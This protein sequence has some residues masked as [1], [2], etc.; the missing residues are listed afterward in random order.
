MRE[1]PEFLQQV[2]KHFP[3][4]TRLIVGSENKS[5]Y[6]TKQLSTARLQHSPCEWVRQATIENTDLP[7][8]VK[9]IAVPC[10]HAT[11]P[12]VPLPPSIPAAFHRRGADGYQSP[13]NARPPSPRPG[14]FPL[15]PIPTAL[16]RSASTSP[17]LSLTPTP[18]CPL[19]GRIHTRRVQRPF[20]APSPKARPPL[21]LPPLPRVWRLL[22]ADSAP[23]PPL[24]SA[25]PALVLRLSFALP[26]PTLGPASQ[27]HCGWAMPVLLGPT[28]AWLHPADSPRAAAL[29]PRIAEVSF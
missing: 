24:S 13:L 28:G 27:S 21:A 3:T 5:R 2:L 14:R 9:A 1:N 20:P 23:L 12:A 29:V 25:S 18:T 16:R 10:R 8:T 4:D 19:H 17:T 11:A 15:P 26:L 6:G 22:A 7:F